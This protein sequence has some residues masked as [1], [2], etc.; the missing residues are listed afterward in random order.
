[1]PWTI[2]WDPI[3]TVAEV[4]CCSEHYLWLWVAFWWWF[5]GSYSVSWWV[6]PWIKVTLE[7]PFNSKDIVLVLIS[8]GTEDIT[9]F[10]KHLQ[11]APCREVSRCLLAPEGQKEG[12]ES[13]YTSHTT[14]RSLIQPSS[15]ETNLQ[16][17]KQTAELSD[18]HHVIFYLFIYLF[19]KGNGAPFSAVIMHL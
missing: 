17:H 3:Y 10:A 8:V 18:Q 13:N 7:Y 6:R 2:C 15:E 9:D 14:V 16:G 4:C 5:L 11:H 12:E 1:M 19:S